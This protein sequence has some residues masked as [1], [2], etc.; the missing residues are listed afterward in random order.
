LDRIMAFSDLKAGGE[1]SVAFALAMVAP[2]GRL[3]VVLPSDCADKEVAV[4]RDLR[5]RNRWVDIQT[6]VL[7]KGQ[8]ALAHLAR[9]RGSRAVVVSAN[10]RGP[11]GDASTRGLADE[12]AAFDCTVVVVPEPK[13]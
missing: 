12:L 7:D 10:R 1:A 3:D 11:Y 4:L 6:V 9:R 8:N 13:P 5:A 2:Q